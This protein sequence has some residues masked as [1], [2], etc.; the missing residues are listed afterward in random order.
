MPN[1]PATIRIWIRFAPATLRE[2]RMR[3]GISG[4]RAVTCRTA[5]PASSAIEIAPIASVPAEPQP[6]SAAWTIV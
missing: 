3:G 6:W 4:W 2:R 5:K 1:R